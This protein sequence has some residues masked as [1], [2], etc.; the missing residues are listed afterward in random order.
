M[1]REAWRLGE[2]VILEGRWR[3]K[4]LIDRTTMEEAHAAV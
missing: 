2:S 1:G 4:R 3:A